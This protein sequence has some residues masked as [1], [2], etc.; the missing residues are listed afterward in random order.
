MLKNKIVKW[1]QISVVGTLIQEWMQVW[2]HGLHA[3]NCS[4]PQ[5]KDKNICW[6]E[7]LV[8]SATLD[9]NST[10]Y[11]MSKHSPALATICFRY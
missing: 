6:L 3:S 2:Q 10:G 9:K 5:V 4:R 8:S 7:Q 11:K 1:E